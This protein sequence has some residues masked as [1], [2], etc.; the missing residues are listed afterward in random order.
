MS[1]I[2]YVDLEDPRMCVAGG[3]RMPLSEAN[4]LDFV[5]VRERIRVERRDAM[6]AIIDPNDADCCHTA[7]GLQ[8]RTEDARR[9]GYQLVKP[10]TVG[11]DRTEKS[12]PLSA[13]ETLRLQI[14]VLPEAVDRPSAAIALSTSTDVTNIDQARTLLRGM[15]PETNTNIEQ[16]DTMSTISTADSA[17][18]RRALDLRIAAL[19][20]TANA[21]GNQAARDEAKKLAHA[22]NILNSGGVAIGEAFTLARLDAR[23]TVETLLKTMR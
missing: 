4:A 14:L 7:S 19:S 5:L 9:D 17:K 20:T 10:S 12:V 16:D 8:M 15:E 23:R 1:K 11:A 3:V 13:A 2:A 18:F 22:R 21:T 6:I